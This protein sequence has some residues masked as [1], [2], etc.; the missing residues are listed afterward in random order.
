MAQVFVMKKI[1]V[2]SYTD[3]NF[4]SVEN[5]TVENHFKYSILR[6]GKIKIYPPL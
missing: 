5:G 4:K 6:L 2:P 1:L 3:E